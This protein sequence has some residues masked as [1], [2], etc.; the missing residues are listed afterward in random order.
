MNCETHVVDVDVRTVTKTEF[1][2]S[3][4]VEEKTRNNN[5]QT[6]VAMNLLDEKESDSANT[7]RVR[8]IFFS[9]S[10]MARGY[11]SLQRLSDIFA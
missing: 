11:L 5:K 8:Y 9:L 3:L 10:L 4:F 2:S 1:Y 6:R 7:H